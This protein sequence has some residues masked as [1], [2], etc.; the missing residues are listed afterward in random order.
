MSE[1]SGSADLQPLRIQDAPAA[2]RY[3]ATLGEPPRLVAF[4]DYRMHDLAIALLHTEVQPGFEGQGIGG[5]L[6]AGVFD[7]LRERGLRVIPKCP[8]IVRWLERHPEQHDV[9]AR[10]LDTPLSADGG[11][12]PA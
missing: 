5:R 12:E 10:P 6:A 1:Q 11:L 7:D 2:S 8:F 9:L 4:V 3:E